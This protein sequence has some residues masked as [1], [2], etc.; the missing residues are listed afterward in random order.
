M[1]EIR[2]GVLGAGQLARMLVEAGRHIR[3]DIK[4][5]AERENEPAC[6]VTPNVV[7]QDPKNPLDLRKFF[8]SCDIITFENEFV[9]CDLIERA[10]I[11]LKVQFRPSLDSVRCM[12]NKL[13]Q[14]K[15][16]LELRIP[17]APFEI[18]HN[19][20]MAMKSL[21]HFRTEVVLKWDRLGYD[22]K[23]VFFLDKKT[24]I[25]LV[26]GFFEEAAKRE[27]VVF[28]E[29]KMSYSS[30]LAILGVRSVHDDFRAY[31]L[32]ISE[33]EKGVCR[34]VKG[35]A[36]SLGVSRSRDAEAVAYAE[37]I[38]KALQYIGLFAIE[39]FE[40]PDGRLVVN[41]LAPRV[42]NSGHYTQ[43]ASDTSQF[44]NHLRALSGTVLGNTDTTPYFAMLNLL[45]PFQFKEVKVATPPVPTSHSNIQI[46]WYDKAELKAG[47]K[48]GHINGKAST[49]FEY[50]TLLE[51]MSEYEKTWAKM[52]IGIENVEE[53]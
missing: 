5:F 47:R 19:A 48:M 18:V 10:A 41:E 52:G 37:A 2:I 40:M 34:W 23:G 53:K 25:E 29:Q 24:P 8:E 27:A 6:F 43:F 44:E 38:S 11:G 14:K 26:Q 39:L 50:E 7:I 42:H 46:Y 45:G 36:K 16:L 35:P 9:D 22:G 51:T 12:Q 33:Q 21:D 32:V 15:L 28:A 30:E 13:V 31:P 1:S 20:E 17:S 3:L 4:V 49:P